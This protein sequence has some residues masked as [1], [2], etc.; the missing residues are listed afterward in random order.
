MVSQIDWTK[1]ASRKLDEMIEY[2]EGEGASGAAVNLVKKV[3]ERIELLKHYPDIGRMAKKAKTIRYIRLDK[4][5]II[6]YRFSGKKMTIVTFFDER[7]NP[8][9]RPF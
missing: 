3:F 5:R 1:R 8:E 4:H 9:K 6:Y 2:L 7:Q